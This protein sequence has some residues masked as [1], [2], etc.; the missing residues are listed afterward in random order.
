MKDEFKNPKRD[1]VSF[2]A[3]FEQ[4]AVRHGKVLRLRKNGSQKQIPLGVLESALIASRS[5]GR[6][7]TRGYQQEPTVGPELTTLIAQRSLPPSTVCDGVVSRPH[8]ARLRFQFSQCASIHRRERENAATCDAHSCA[9]RSEPN[10][11]SNTEPPLTCGEFQ[12]HQA[13]LPNHRL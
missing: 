12:R 5:I 3:C 11:R 9:V 13:L 10:G 8:A 4:L 6:F 1:E 7:Q 2:V